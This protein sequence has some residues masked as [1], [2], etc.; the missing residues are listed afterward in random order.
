[1]F[2]AE[3]NPIAITAPPQAKADN[4]SQAGSRR[5]RCIRVTRKYPKAVVGRHAS[6]PSGLFRSTPIGMISHGSIRRRSDTSTATACLTQSPLSLVAPQPKPASR[7]P[8]PPDWTRPH[9]GSSPGLCRGLWRLR[10]SGRLGRARPG[11]RSWRRIRQGR[12][13]RQGWARG[14]R[15]A[16]GHALERRVGRRQTRRQGQAL[17]ETRQGRQPVTHPDRPLCPSRTPGL[18]RPI[19][20]N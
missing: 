4:G 14:Q 3:P 9:P 6:V 10:R 1:M 20:R 13:S 2:I 12:R 15:R 8:R 11:D 7:Q 17:G 16:G 18:C 5:N 19:A